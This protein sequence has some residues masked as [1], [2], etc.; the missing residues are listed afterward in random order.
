MVVLALFF[1][2]IIYKLASKI[3]DMFL[4]KYYNM[5]ALSTFDDFFLVDDKKC[6]L[7][8]VFR[9]SQFDFEKMSLYIKTNF[10]MQIDGAATRLVEV[11]GKNYWM[12]LS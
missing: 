3:L 8:G 2:A 1:G 4:C 12:N 5:R 7:S 9:F 11:F 10:A 6:V